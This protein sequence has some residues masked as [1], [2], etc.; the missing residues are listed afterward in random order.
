MFV[1]L[2]LKKKIFFWYH[3]CDFSDSQLYCDVGLA[4]R[5]YIEQALAYLGDIRTI[6]S[7]ISIIKIRSKEGFS[8]YLGNSFHEDWLSLNVSLTALLSIY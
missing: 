8:K 6:V 7:N 3:R 2:N 1:F 4:T 5:N